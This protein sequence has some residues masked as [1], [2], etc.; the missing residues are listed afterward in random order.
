MEV[1]ELRHPSGGRALVHLHGGHVTSWR[2]A[3]GRE[4]L[5]L[6]SASRFEEGV[7]IRGGIPVIF[8]QFADR[9]PLA[10]H[11]FARLSP[12][13][14]L[15]MNGPAAARFELVDSAATRALWPAAFRLELGVAVGA[16]HLEVELTVTA[17]SR[18]DFTAALHTYLAVADVERVSVSGLQG[19]RFESRAEGIARESQAG[20]DLRVRGELDRVYLD[21]PGPIVVHG[22]AAAARVVVEGD[23]FPDVVLWNPGEEKGRAIA[24]LGA[25]EYRRMLCVEAAVVGA[26]VRL[27][28]GGRWQGRQ[29]LHTDP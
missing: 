11:G 15:G 17:R 8:P 22:P 1:V 28:P 9:G 20:S 4:R 3:D 7:A 12:W 6:S 10:K 18:L 26:P 5:F 14:F 2:T 13:R 24:D 16:R 21:V 25:G 23:G 29:R 27:D 19:V